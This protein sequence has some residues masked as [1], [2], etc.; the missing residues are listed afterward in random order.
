[1]GPNP[2]LS[3]GKA[4]YGQEPK[5]KK[6]SIWRRPENETKLEEEKSGAGYKKGPGYWGPNWDYP[7]DDK[8]EEV[9][10]SFEKSYLASLWLMWNDMTNVKHVIDMEHETPDELLNE[11]HVWF[12]LFKQEWYVLYDKTG[13][14]ATFWFK[15]NCKWAYA[16]FLHAKWRKW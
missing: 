12:P 6:R 7:G 13:N 11:L 8:V 16:S 2:I 10:N 1:M 15:D 5:I 14:F 9:N 3:G 4:I